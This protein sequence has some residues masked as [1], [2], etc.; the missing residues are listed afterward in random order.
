MTRPAESGNVLFMIL[1][2]VA[3]IALLTAAISGG[4]TQNKNIDNETLVLRTSEVQ[5]YAKELEQAVQ[6]ITR[7]AA[8]SET[9]FRFAHPEAPSDYGTITDTPSLQIFSPEG[10]AATYRAPPADINDGSAWEFYGTTAVPGIGTSRADLVAVLPNVT[11][12]F[13]TRLN[14]LVGQSAAPQ[15][16]SA[17]IYTGATGRFNASTQYS[18]SP[19]T[20]N[21]SSFA[22][23]T[24]I[25]AAK[26]A[27]QACV[28]C[29]DSSYHFYTVIF[30]R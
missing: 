5:R 1:I 15:D 27:P 7:N 24:T 9:D 6:I 4:D 21:E 2:A 28:Q 10:G 12:A 19:N 17:C 16:T 25:S 29:S 26:P 23:D 13:C 11:A 30:P 14:T 18:S 20:M 8:V 22:Q 3:L